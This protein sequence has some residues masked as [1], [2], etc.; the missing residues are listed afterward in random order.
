M[1]CIG[2]TLQQKE[3]LKTKLG[4][5]ALAVA[6]IDIVDVRINSNGINNTAPAYVATMDYFE[7]NTNRNTTWYLTTNG[8]ETFFEDVMGLAPK[9]INALQDKGITHPQDLG[10]FDSDNFDSVI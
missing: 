5:D 7:T 6:I 8:V 2:L 10:N 4:D 9:H 3:T 1:S